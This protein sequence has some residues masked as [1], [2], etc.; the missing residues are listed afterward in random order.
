MVSGDK[1][2]A[3]INAVAVFKTP[4]IEG[5]VVVS[6]YRDGVKLL[7]HFTRLPPGKHGFHIHKAGDLRG[8]GCQ[9]LCE[10]YDIGKNA[11][12]GEPGSSYQRHT[13]DL[14]NIELKGSK[15]QKEYYIKGVTTSDLW[16]RSIIV[17]E[18]EDDL[19]RGPFEDSPI[20]GH[21]GKRIGCAIFGRSLCSNKLQYNKT[22]KHSK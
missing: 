17:H 13:G 19:G 16:G 9:G 18:D 4:A 6:N 15:F 12:G 1:T 11:H 10:H 20:T 7:A 22:R 21:S 3:V 5:E 2:T 14:G 8:E